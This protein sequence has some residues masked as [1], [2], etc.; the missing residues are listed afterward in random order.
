METIN[1]SKDANNLFDHIKQ[2]LKSP[3]MFMLIVLIGSFIK[4]V[5]P[6]KIDVLMTNIKSEYLTFIGGV[7]DLIIW[8]LIIICSFLFVFHFASAVIHSLLNYISGKIRSGDF[9][10]AVIMYRGN[11]GSHIR[12]ILL[13]R[14]LFIMI[15][16]LY[17]FNESQFISYFETISHSVIR[18]EM[19]FWFAMIGFFVSVVLI[20]SFWFAITSIYFKYIDIYSI[21]D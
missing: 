1:S 17:I 15:G 4:I 10:F 3:E 14:W 20:Q 5:L 11:R 12:I 19:N 9:G 18:F 8:F 7:I 21:K 16:L 2:L 6:D 13:S